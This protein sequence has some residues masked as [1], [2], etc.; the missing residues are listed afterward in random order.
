MNLLIL[1][2]TGGVGLELVR[3]SVD[4]GHAV[5][6][7]V[8]TPERLQAF[9]NR[10]RIVEGDPLNATALTQALHGQDAVLS[11]FGPRV[12]VA[13][14]D[15]DLL[16]RFAFA[17]TR[18]MAASRVKRAIVVSTAFLFKDALLPPAHLVGRLF[19]SS[20][21]KDTTAMEAIVAQSPLDWTLVR[22]PQLIDKPLTGKYRVRE[23]HL[24]TFGFNISRA[25]VADCMIQIAEKHSFSRKVVGVSR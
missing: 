7:F 1:G 22:P 18:A 20:V 3:Q 9:A 11:G 14:G 4:R 16:E 17:L 19:F 23:G 15:E 6:A 2:A 10:I 24:P 12:P 5:T 25:N 13:K 21:V 8:R